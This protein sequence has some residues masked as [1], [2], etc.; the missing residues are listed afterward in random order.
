M[1]EEY[2]VKV[3]RV[4][5]GGTLICSLV[6]S[7]GFSSKFGITYN[8]LATN[9]QPTYNQLATSVVLNFSVFCISIVTTFELA[10]NKH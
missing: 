5:Q 4:Q 7:Y 3:R 1:T 8:Q 6:N 2:F 10:L 9:L